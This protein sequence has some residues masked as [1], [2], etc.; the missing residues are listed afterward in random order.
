MLT[1]L[2]IENYALIEKIEVNFSGGINIITG[3]TGAGKSILVDAITLIL[4]GRV[5]SSAIFDNTKK[6]IIEAHFSLKS[7][8]FEPFFEQHNLDYDEITILRREIT[9]NN[10]NRSFINDTPVNNSLLKEI[11]S[12]LVEIVSQYH[13]L[14]LLNTAFQLDVVDDF[15]HNSELLKKYENGFKEYYFIKKRLKELLDNEAN[16][17]ADEGYY[18]FLLNELQ[19]ASLCLGEQEA[20]ENELDILNNIEL[21]KRKLNQ[22]LYHLNDEE[23]NVLSQIKEIKN[24]LES[25]SSFNANYKEF[26]DRVQSVL[27]ELK[28]ITEELI[29]EEDILIF[30]N[31]R[32][33]E[34]N[35]RLQLLFSLQQKHKVNSVNTLIEVQ[36]E[37]TNKL[38]LAQSFE[39]EIMALKNRL[40]ASEKQLGKWADAL[41]LKRKAVV[42]DLEQK[43]IEI[44]KDLSM[45][46]AQFVIEFE[47]NNELTSKGIDKITFNFSANKGLAPEDLSKVASGGEIS[48]LMLSVK[49]VIS[50]QKLLP[51]IIFDEIDS[52]IS[53]DTALK[54]GRILK[55]MSKN[56]QII[57]ITHLP[58][59]AGTATTHYKVYKEDKNNLACTYIKI[60]TYDE[61]IQNIAQMISGHS[62]TEAALK[63]AQELIQ[64]N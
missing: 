36:Q 4:G 41:S 12:K 52:G 63:T 21:I 61:R 22:A 32:L 35:E 60:L 33:T 38:T 44:L 39:E 34:L 51:C 14:S 11:S 57:A 27:I 1:Y 5:D 43:I 20:I 54:T 46:D 15:A 56:M 3:E 64:M 6:C 13:S 37:L 49:S 8:D 48:R 30:S 18:A 53:G 24:Y 10:K 17:K 47:K 16:K 59:I 23:Q 25:I 26:A 45:P 50:Q 62:V 58:Q 55:K 9:P 28:D 19:N 29:K 7:Y 31:E 40:V 2:L 42:K